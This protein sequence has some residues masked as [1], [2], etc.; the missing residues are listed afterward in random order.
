MILVIEFVTDDFYWVADNFLS[1][2]DFGISQM[3]FLCQ[4]IM[5]TSSACW[6]RRL[7]FF[8]FTVLNKPCIYGINPTRS[9]CIIFLYVTG[10]DLLLFFGGVL[11]LSYW[12]VLVCNILSFGI[13]I[14]VWCWC[15]RTGGLINELCSTPSSS[16]FWKSL[17]KID[18]S[19]SE[20]IW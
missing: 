4:L 16:V 1:W 18:V 8:F 2:M 19:S 13:T 9:W 7:H 10:F 15:Q 20:N 14:F 17:C 12:E 6:Y 5:F 11:Y 3:S